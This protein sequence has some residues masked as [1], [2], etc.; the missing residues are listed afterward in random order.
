M[1]WVMWMCI[2]GPIMDQEKLSPLR[3]TYIYNSLSVIS[4]YSLSIEHAGKR[5]KK[6]KGPSCWTTELAAVNVTLLWFYWLHALGSRN[7]IWTEHRDM[8]RLCMGTAIKMASSIDLCRQMENLILAKYGWASHK[9]KVEE[10][11]LSI[12]LLLTVVLLSFVYKESTS[13]CVC[14]CV[15]GYINTHIQYI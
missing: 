5:V 2:N 3:G 4:M 14:V 10:S 8:R 13:V 12:S 7:I 1:C 11:E 9:N 6:I 15:F